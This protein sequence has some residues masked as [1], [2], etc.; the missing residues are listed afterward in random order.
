MVAEI[1]KA[2]AGGTF[3]YVALVE[4]ILEEFQDHGHHQ[5]DNKDDDPH[6]KHDEMTNER[7]NKFVFVLMG[8]GVMSIFSL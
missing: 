5:H 2:I 6:H 1:I 8:V 7:N 3:I 4:I